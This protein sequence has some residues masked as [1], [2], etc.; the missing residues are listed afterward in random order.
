MEFWIWN[1]Y[2]RAFDYAKR[3]YHPEIVELLKNGLTPTSKRLVK[4]NRKQILEKIELKMEIL[5]EKQK[6]QSAISKLENQLH[7]YQYLDAVHK[8]VTN[9]LN[10]S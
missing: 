1:I 7:Q 5:F 6:H 10:Q 4:R 9:I 3:N 2:T 8:Q